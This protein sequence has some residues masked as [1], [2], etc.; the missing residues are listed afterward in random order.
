MQGTV[1]ALLYTYST[2]LKVFDKLI[3][4]LFNIDSELLWI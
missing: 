1:Y 3:A 4:T 2:F